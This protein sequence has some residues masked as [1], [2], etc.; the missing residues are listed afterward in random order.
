MMSLDKSFEIQSGDQDDWKLI[1][2]ANYFCCHLESECTNTQCTNVQRWILS[3][4]QNH[5]MEW[6]HR[7]F[8][9]LFEFF[10]SNVLLDGSFYL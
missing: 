2:E 6:R 8:K 7:F 10:D 4:A 9:T 1:L 3:V 5:A